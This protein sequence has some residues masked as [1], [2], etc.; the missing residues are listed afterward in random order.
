MSHT[1]RSRAYKNRDWERKTGAK[2]VQKYEKGQTG[3][4]ETVKKK[5]EKKK[6]QD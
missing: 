3:E 5:K 4:R 1:K 2:H 6:K